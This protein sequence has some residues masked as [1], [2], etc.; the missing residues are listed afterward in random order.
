[1]RPLEGEPSILATVSAAG[2]T[3]LPS[4][5]QRP[6]S[7]CNC[8]RV[9]DGVCG[10]G[11]LNLGPSQRTSYPE[12]GQTGLSRERAIPRDPTTAPAFWIWWPPGNTRPGSQERGNMCLS[13][14]SCGLGDGIEAIRGLG[15]WLPMPASPGSTGD[16][17]AWPPPAGATEPQ[18]DVQQERLC[19]LVSV[20]TLP[21]AI[22]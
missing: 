3:G 12:G 7:C 18:E 13:P 4:N 8:S 16:Q 9:E 2:Q 22:F 5:P 6:R 19:T 10:S 11:S 1:M 14:R 17:E 21:V 15:T 20:P